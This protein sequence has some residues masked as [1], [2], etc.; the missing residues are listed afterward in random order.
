VLDP[1]LPTRII[2]DI[3]YQ[4][5]S[6]S[7][8]ASLL[9][10][11]TR[12]YNFE[13]LT[14][15]EL[16]TVEQLLP[17]F[18]GALQYQ[19]QTIHNYFFVGQ[20]MLMIGD[21]EQANRYLAAGLNRVKEEEIEVGDTK[22][23]VAESY[24]CISLASAAQGNRQQALGAAQAAESL[25]PQAAAYVE[26]VGS[27][28]FELEDYVASKRKIMQALQIQPDRKRSKILLRAIE[29]ALAGN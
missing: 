17:K 19:A 22:L 13:T 27:A 15:E 3:E 4:Q 5:V 20:C 24:Y 26:A 14:D 9:P 8:Q 11:A 2:N 12:Y 1:R 25:F 7:A 10:I 29:K 18:R 28:L 23:I 16:A 6:E 21:Y